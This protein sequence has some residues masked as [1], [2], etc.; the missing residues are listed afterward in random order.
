MEIRKDVMDL[1]LPIIAEQAFVIIMGVV[2]TIMAGHLGR[3][4]VSAIGM[5][6][7]LNNIFIAF[8][9][10]LAVGG[11][12][13]IAQYFGKRDIKKVNESAIHAVLA[14]TVISVIITL[15]IYIFR[16]PVVSILYGSADQSV[17]DNVLVYLNITLLTYPLIAV[18]SV[19]SGVLRGVGDSKTPMKVSIIMNIL[20]VLLS[21]TL[22]YGFKMGN[23]HFSLSIP[24]LGVKG[25]ALGIAIARTVGALLILYTLTGGTR[26][27]SLRITRDFRVN[28]DI[29]GSVFGIGIP[30]SVENV[31]FQIGKLI[32]QVF[33]VGFGTASIAANYVANSVFGVINI[34]GSA[35]S[36]AATTIIGQYM[37]RRDSDG[38]NDT[39]V[40]VTKLT[41]I[42]L[43]IISSL[44]LPFAN[45]IARLYST[46]TEV[47]NIAAMLIRTASLSMPT[48][49]ATSFILPA[50]LKG[51]GDA[52]YTMIIS[53]LSMWLFRVGGG[54][55]LCTT[56]G[57]GVLGVWL[58]MYIDWVFRGIMFYGRLKSGKW[59]NNVVIKAN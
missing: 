36:L 40:Y 8:F 11:T 6:D 44:T 14:S 12:V 51:A 57:L 17:F 52:K 21:Y 19:S 16:Y 58:G 38:A 43:L 34:S 53:I 59:K 5:V 29:L 55:I 1:S 22:I 3:E 39:L 20:N 33:V 9:S 46:D 31:L 56:L 47:I 32:T 49:W 18:T 15:L 23:A 13:V 48:L 50:G 25:A 10:A 54:Y 28:Y 26:A 41:A 24:A 45:I 7:S 37:G 35:L 2:N 42:C 27:V 30:A 4:A